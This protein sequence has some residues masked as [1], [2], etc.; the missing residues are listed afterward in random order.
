MASANPVN[1]STVSPRVANAVKSAQKFLP[2][3]VRFFIDNDCSMAEIN[4]LVI[5]ESGDLLALDAKVA[6]DDNAM[7][8]HKPL[9]AL[10]DRQ[11]V[12]ALCR[13]L[14]QIIDRRPG[15]PEGKATCLQPTDATGFPGQNLIHRPRQ[16]RLVNC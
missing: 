2:Q 8:R 14:P 4:P 16:Q 9:E 5:T 10:R 13:F 15:V 6:F 7:F 1:S 11:Q 3:V 12:G